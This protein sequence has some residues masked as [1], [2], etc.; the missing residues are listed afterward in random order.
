MRSFRGREAG[1]HLVSQAAPSQGRGTDPN[2]TAARGVRS[3][4][5]HNSRG[6]IP[7][8]SSRN[9]VITAIENGWTTEYEN[10][11]GHIFLNARKTSS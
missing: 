4:T 11:S 8:F 5:E 6:R 9:F 7:L 3:A 2:E 1:A 10:R